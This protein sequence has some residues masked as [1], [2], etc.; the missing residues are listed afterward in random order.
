MK[1]K[2]DNSS[3]GLPVY[4]NQLY[5][6]LYILQFISQT[7]FASNMQYSSV[8]TVCKNR[9]RGYRRPRGRTTEEGVA[10]TPAKQ[11]HQVQLQKESAE[12]L[13]CAQKLKYHLT[14]RFTS[15]VDP[16]RILSSTE[17]NCCCLAWVLVK[18]S[19][20]VLR[21]GLK[22]NSKVIFNTTTPRLHSNFL[23]IG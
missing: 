16:Q 3:L 6:K 10:V 19:T 22:I 21:F 23:C 7:M 13:I 4:Q 11:G 20:L 15:P 5:S 1:R 8:H 9:Q 18:V 17:F 2:S 12:Q 14:L